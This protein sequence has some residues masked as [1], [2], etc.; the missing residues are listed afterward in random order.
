MGEYARRCKS[1]GED[2][3]SKADAITPVNST[4]A[5]RPSGP[6][7]WPQAKFH[8]SLYRDCQVYAC[9]EREKAMSN[10]FTTRLRVD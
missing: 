4:D 5:E 3:S 7:W 9:A 8:K 10:C 6:W 2:K 1:E